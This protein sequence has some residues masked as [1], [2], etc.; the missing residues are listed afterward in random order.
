MAAAGRV[1][2]CTDE[3]C[4]RQIAGILRN[5]RA[6]GAPNI[7]DARELGLGGASD[8][9]LMAELG[10]RGFAALVTL[11]SRI[12]SAA[13]RRAAWQQSGLTLGSVLIWLA[14]GADC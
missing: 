5:L 14:S 9:A 12:L 4:G 7:R 13:M 2:F 11:D 3:A 6:P 10:R 8:E 1:G